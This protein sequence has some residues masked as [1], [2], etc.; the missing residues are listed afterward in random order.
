VVS[1]VDAGDRAKQ[2]RRRQIL[3]AAKAASITQAAVAACDT[4]DG[5]AD[6]VM[7]D[8][9]A[10]TGARFNVDAMA[11]AAGQTPMHPHH[12]RTS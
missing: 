8:P 1:T 12:C 11:C 3:S 7:E 9:R 5:V 2:E 10:C 6:G 4:L